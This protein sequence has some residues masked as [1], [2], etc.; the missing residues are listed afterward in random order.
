MDQLIDRWNAIWFPETTAVR[1]AVCRIIVAAAQ[2]FV[3]RQS[4]D[5]HLWLVESNEAFIQP[6]VIIRAIGTLLPAEIFRTA[7]FF[8][9]L[10][11]VTMVAG[12]T[13]LIGLLTRSSAF[14]FALGN[15]IL[16][17]HKYSYGEK[18]HPEAILCIF[19]MLLAFSPSG[20]CLSID[21]MIHHQQRDAPDSRAWGISAKLTTAVWPLTVTQ[22]LF[23]L[24]YLSA[25]LCKL[26]QGGL[27]WLNGYTLQTHLLTDAVRWDRP[28]G[29]WL[30]QQH[31]LCILLSIGTIAFEVLFF[32]TLFWRRA[33][34]FFLLG[35]TLMHIGI[36]VLQAAPFFQLIVLYA[37][38]ID[39]ERL[40][41]NWKTV[42][43]LHQT[44]A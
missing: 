43:T 1:L 13:T 30:A 10:Y 42:P 39:F 5:H 29:L 21:A 3:F 2:L 24:I 18:H 37:V 16:I 19:L 36:Y 14:V 9:V 27:A 31:E 7:E 26:H 41:L 20:R 25:G 33:V 44:P 15:W 22:V 38:F 6:Q 40:Y 28:L 35:G 17:A 4:L 34:P 23:A 12:I 8:T 11:V 32:V